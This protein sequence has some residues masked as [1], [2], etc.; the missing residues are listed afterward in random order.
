MSNNTEKNNIN[1]NKFQMNLQE[2]RN[3]WRSDMEVLRER[4]KKFGYENISL[5]SFADSK[6]VNEQVNQSPNTEKMTEFL[7]IR[8][9]YENLIEQY[10]ELWAEDWVVKELNKKHAIIHIDQTYILTEK[11]DLYGNPDFTIESRASFRHF[12]EDERIINSRGKGCCKADIW[13]RSPERRKYEGIVFDPSIVG[14]RGKY[15]NIW[16]GFARLPQQGVESKYWAH[17]RDNIC[18]ENL[19]HYRYVRKWLA[20]IFQHPDIVHTALVLCGSQGVGKNSF[21]EPLGVIFGDHYVLLSSMEELV[22]HFNYHLKNAVLI[23]ANEALWG[24]H[25]KDLGK[26]KTMITEQECLIESKGKDRIMVKNF[27]HLILS[28]NEDWPVHIDRDDRRF[29]VLS[30][31]DAHKEDIEYFKA[32]QNEL[33]SGGYEALLYDLLNEDLKE[34]DPRKFPHSSAAFDIKMRSESS[35]SRFIYDALAN[36]T[37]D[38]EGDEDTWAEIIPKQDLY[39][40]Y[41]GWCMENEETKLQQNIFGAS[42][43]KIIPGL[44]YC[45]QMF[46]GKRTYVYCF[47]PLEQTREAFC[48][49][50]KINKEEVFNN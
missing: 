11:T 27:K 23:H 4:C 12:Y 38:S 7:A 47:P 16:K 41:K 1:Q 50:F 36:G 18:S 35:V 9:A 46:G 25:K 48:K 19:E 37:F 33:D 22:S 29:F 10:K 6:W 20:Y 5:K 2:R 30:V 13:L 24:G 3:Q 32:I 21:V 42:L 34:F 14:H 44:S 17:V 39:A 49:S 40:F 31:S 15:Y 45:R 28:S 8:N 43:K 26:V